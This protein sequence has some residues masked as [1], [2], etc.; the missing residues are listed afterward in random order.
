[1]RVA[2]QAE[3]GDVGDRA[4]PDAPDDV[5][6]V[7]VQG[8]HP[9][10]RLRRVGEPLLRAAEDE[11]RPEGLRQIERVAGARAGLGP[12]PVRMDGA[13][14]REPVLRLGVADRVPPGQ[15]RPGRPHLAVG[16]KKNRTYGFYRQ[17]LRKGCD[18]QRDERQAAHREDVVEGVRRRDRPEVV[19]IVDDRREEVDREHERAFVVEPVDGRVVRGVEAHE[20]VLRLGGDEAAQQLLEPRR[21]VLRG[22]AAR[23]REV[24]QLRGCDVHEVNVNERRRPWAAAARGEERLAVSCIGRRARDSFTLGM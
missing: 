15:Q 22:A 6:R 19:R 10:H 20:Q 4:R 11:R 13:D 16:R 24:G 1:M 21:G 8:A 9:A 23:R 14:D 5:G 2:E 7:P 17:L 18:R 3:A 12:D